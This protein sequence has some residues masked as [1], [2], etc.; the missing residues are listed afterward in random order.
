MKPNGKH[1][2]VR[3][4]FLAL[5]GVGLLS[6]VGQAETTHGTFKLPD[7]T[8]WGKM[9]L[10]PGEYEFDVRNESAGRIVTVRSKDSG[11]S[12]MIMSPSSSDMASAEGTKL[13]LES[14]EQGRYVSALCLGDSGVMLNYAAPKAGKAT[15]LVKSPPAPTTMASASGRE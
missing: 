5:C 8:H 6:A 13:L 12:G 9:L 11:W 2:V 10:A 3:I 14:S 7:E 4:A 15:R 1:F